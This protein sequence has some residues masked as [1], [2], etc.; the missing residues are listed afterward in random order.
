MRTVVQFAFVRE[1]SFFGYT[2]FATHARLLVVPA[3][4]LAAFLCLIVTLIVA[5]CLPPVFRVTLVLPVPGSCTLPP[6]LAAVV[7]TG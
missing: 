5:F 3:W 1:R 6:S 7:S 2:E 4:L